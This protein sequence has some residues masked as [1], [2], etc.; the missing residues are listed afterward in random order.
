MR[1]SLLQV[2]VGEETP[3]GEDFD[4]P[5]NQLSLHWTSTNCPLRIAPIYLY[6]KYMV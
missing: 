1:G 2:E 4:R 5:G 6:K 3:T